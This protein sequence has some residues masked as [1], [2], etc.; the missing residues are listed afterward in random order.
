ML[1]PGSRF[2]A[3]PGQKGAKT[4]QAA[5]LAALCSVAPFCL[6]PAHAQTVGGLRGEVQ[7]GETNDELQPSNRRTSNRATGTAQPAATRS[8]TVGGNSSQADASP[9]YLP[10]SEGALTAEEEEARQ[11]EGALPSIFDEDERQAT[12]DPFASAPVPAARPTRPNTATE[13]A[14]GAEQRAGEAGARSRNGPQTAAE[15]M[16][17]AETAD[18][19]DNVLTTGTVRQSTVDAIEADERDIDS[20][21][22][23]ESPI[24][25][26]E[27]QAEENP[28]APLGIRAGNFILRPS[29]EQG[30]TYTTNVDSSQEGGSAVV[31]ESTARLNAVSDW[32]LHT[33]TFDAYGIMRRSVS[34]EEYKQMEGGFDGTLDLDLGHEYKLKTALGYSVKPEGAS[35]PVIIG[36]V[37][38]DPLRHTFDASVGLTKEVGKFQFGVIAKAERNVYEDAELTTGTVSQ[39][40]R[41]ST[42]ATLALRTGY[43]I[44]P[45]ITPFVEVEVGR[46]IYDEEKDA[47]GFER[48]ADRLGGRVGVAVD[49]GEKL[50]GEFSAGWLRESFDDDELDPISGANLAANLRWSPERGTIVGLNASTT[51]EG[52]TTPDESGS[53]LHSGRLT[54]EREIR[55]NLT[56][57]AALGVD[58]RTYNSTDEHDL[59]LMAET[60]ATWWLNRYLGLTGRLK[61]E[62]QRSDRQGRD[63]DANSVFLGMKVQR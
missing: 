23:R 24:E 40:D 29:F 57:N 9:R 14:T 50:T 27:R 62:R 54:L 60:G 43:E 58:W 22:E 59:T 44:S 46:R 37:I 31:S 25:G 2:C 11:R 45:A 8:G 5:V 3:R 12:E 7:E 51:V 35:S 17:A 1:R 61:H 52:T 21:A 20:R 56:A 4:L 13:R 10:I 42:L 63:Y 30:F 49:T 28:Y 32:D 15:R 38:E 55:A 53:L 16:R 19:E 26:I 36:D 48:S 47:G 6:Q 34:G 41:N 18:E 39:K 33:A